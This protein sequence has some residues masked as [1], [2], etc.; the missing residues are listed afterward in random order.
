MPYLST[1]DGEISAGIQEFRNLYHLLSE[2]CRWHNA[3]AS[4][5]CC[6]RST[7]DFDFR[8]SVSDTSFTAG[9]HIFPHKLISFLMKNKSKL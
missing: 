8:I 3:Q 7:V 9:K 2:S 6:R 4:I 1:L 5:F